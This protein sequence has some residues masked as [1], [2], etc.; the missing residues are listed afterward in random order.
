M[1]STIDENGFHKERFQELRLG[2]SQ[3]WID[4]GLPDVSQN[5]TSVPGRMVSQQANLQE[6]VDSMI[7]VVADSFNPYSVT[8]AQQSRLAPVM[9]KTRN[10]QSY[11]V[12]TCTITTDAN[13]ANIPANKAFQFS[14]P[15]NSKN[16]FGVI[17]AITIAPNS[18]ATV[19]AEAINYGP[20]SAAANTLT[21][22][23]TPIFGVVSVDNSGPSTV[24]TNRETD[25]QLRFR[26]LKSSAQDSTTLAGSFSA[27]SEIDGVSYVSIHDRSSPLATALNIQP[28]EEFYIIDG[29][30]DDVI[31]STMM[32]VAVAGGII[33][34]ND[35]AGADI[36][37]ASATNPANNQ[38]TPYSW[39]RP[40]DKPVFVKIQVSP[41]ASAPA[42]YVAQIKLSISNYIA[43]L[44]V[45]AKIMSSRVAAAAQCATDGFDV[46]DCKVGLADPAS[47][48]I[49]Q[50]QPFERGSI[51]D[52]NIDVVI[53]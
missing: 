34:K 15:D 32:N 49:A 8:G 35:V 33:T 17:S 24:G 1:P 44:D 27:I 7:Q 2:I 18:T 3:Y 11:S 50:L 5:T 48:N 28:G 45:G 12:V 41:E 4:F 25:P 46:L 19:V 14:D 43:D 13:G 53:S 47:D 52:A 22:I 10:K 51:T 6:R 16:K 37:T 9:G 42:D 26:M 30:N 36:V 29:G 38:P 23:N 21:K 20:I 31:A 39:A 40:S